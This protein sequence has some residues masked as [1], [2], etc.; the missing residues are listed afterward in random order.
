MVKILIFICFFLSYSIPAFSF[1]ALDIMSAIS[2]SAISTTDPATPSD[3]IETTNY[4]GHG[5]M[6]PLKV[7]D[8]GAGF[9]CVNTPPLS[10]TE[11][12]VMLKGT[13]DL[14]N[15][16]LASLTVAVQNEYTNEYKAI[17][18]G[19]PDATSDCWNSQAD[20][21]LDENG[22]FSVKAGLGTMPAQY[23]ILITAAKNEGSSQEYRLRTSKVI[24][25]VLSEKDIKVSV[26]GKT[27]TVNIDL[28][29]GCQA[30]DFVGT[31][32]GGVEATVTNLI[33]NA[34]GGTKQ[35]TEKTNIASGGIFSLCLPLES[36]ANDITVS[37]CNAATGYDISKCP[38]VK[39]PTISSNATVDGLE[40]IKEPALIYS[41]DVDPSVNI[42]FKIAGTEGK[43]CDEAKVGFNFNRNEPLKICADGS[44]IYHLELTPETGINIGT[45]LHGEDVFSFTFGWGNINSPFDKSGRTKKSDELWTANAGGFTIGKDFL[46]DTV[47][48]LINNYLRSDEFKAMLVKLPEL[49][50]KKP[51]GASNP[52]FKQS[53][54]DAIEEIKNSIP[55]CAKK[56]EDVKKTGI[57]LSVAPEAEL[58]EI[59]QVEFKQ[60]AISFILNAE[61]LKVSLDYFADKDENGEPDIRPMPLKIGFRKIY[62]PIDMRVDRKGDKPL[63]LMTSD[64][65]DCEYKSKHACLGRPAILAPK[66]FLGNATKG[67][68]FVK[69]DDKIEKDCIGVNITNAQ[70]GIFSTTVLDAINELLYCNGSAAITYILREYIKEVPIQIGCPK[71]AYP[72]DPL[73]KIGSCGAGGITGDK[74]WVLPI[75]LDLL[76]NQFN[77]TERGISGTV[78]AMVGSESFYSRMAAELKK[79]ET[80]YI[81]KPFLN[82]QTSVASG[83]SNYDMGVSLGEDL[84]NAMLF[85]LSQQDPVEMKDGVFDWDIHEQFLKK[86]GF[87]SVA[88]CDEFKPT[89]PDDTPSTLCNLRPRVGDILGSSLVSNGYFAQK[90]PIMIRIRGNRKLAPHVNFFSLDG[91]QFIDLQFADIDLSFYALKTDGS[92]PL[93]RYSNYTLKLDANGNPI[94]LS[95]NPND[96]NP[97]NGQITKFKLSAAIAVEITDITTDD[98]DPS[99]LMFKVRPDAALSRIVFR[100]VPGGNTTVIS[101]KSLISAFEEKINYGLNIFSEP[102]KAIK[103]KLPKE[104]DIKTP[105]TPDQFSILGLEKIVFGKDGFQLKVEES[106]EFIDIFAKIKF[107]QSIYL[108]LQKNTFELPN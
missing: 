3:P 33:T 34:S 38:N 45:I 64:S 23:S 101:D 48:G 79:P 41:A 108:D 46:T 26:N 53:D 104:I 94:I 68:G 91:K 99:H 106:Q 75:G 92:V 93:D 81:Q 21:C 14:K 60:D 32:T 105:A 56:D 90:Q 27:A 88:K 35:V 40:W 69:C 22:Y 70:T 74:G 100:P 89:S 102:K 73:V 52:L 49:F 28:L 31:S 59:T 47:K 63:F 11:D 6:T 19:G 2:G 82:S 37:V 8:I 57:K 25:P 85:M 51:G 7:C 30:C 17:K 16:K 10:V 98:T 87:D 44:G 5:A 66:D 55:M 77:V 24:A 103:I 71:Q 18:L 96:P 54:K 80:G 84:I 4:C 43:S 107:V 78:P 29:H 42:S 50:S 36:G 62:S 97:D 20:F 86:A 39:L 15:Y 72:K 9:L 67:G 76:N 65:T 95:M 58:I 12:Y 83:T 61:N 13:T 1:N